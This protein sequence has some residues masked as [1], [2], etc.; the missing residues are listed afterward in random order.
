VRSS[1][2]VDCRSHRTA[3]ADKLDEMSYQAPRRRGRTSLTAPFLAGARLAGSALIGSLLV[4]GCSSAHGTGTSPAPGAGA[5]SATTA[6]TS[7]AGAQSTAGPSPAAG[8][9]RPRKI[10]VIMEENHSIQQ[11][12]PSGMPYLWSLAQRYA[13]ATDWSDVSHPSLPNYLA[14]FG[15]SDFNNPQDCAPGPGCSYP[16]PSVFGQALARGETAKAYE[17]SMPQPCDQSFVGNY[18][19]NHNPW[20]YFPSEAANCQA[21]DVP[22]GTPS[23]G[24]LAAD[25]HRGTLPTVGLVTPDLIHDGHNGTPAQA[26]AWLQTWIPAL[27]SGPDWRSGRLAIVVVFD[28]G[29]TT[30]Q[31]PFVLMDPGLSGIKIS[32]PANQYA[33]TRL[34]DKVIGAP[35]LRQAAGAA[36]VASI[37]VGAR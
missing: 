26:D 22:A 1:F 37:L 7:T 16:G 14:I 19:V 8:S 9:A 2:Y 27:M 30:E 33:L 34:I 21:N 12:F 5:S 36:D 20:A 15:G 6:A 11:I 17:E 10:L 35:P 4:V 28:E 23:G 31:V 29:E 18:D 32:K 24:A 13:Y 25:V 3:A